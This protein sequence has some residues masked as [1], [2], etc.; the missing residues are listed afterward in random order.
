[1]FVSKA[2]FCSCTGVI[3]AFL[4]DTH[5]R[6]LVEIVNFKEELGV[7]GY[8]LGRFSGGAIPLV[9]APQALG[10]RAAE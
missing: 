7:K 4:V 1:M 6:N 10:H 2:D 8:R 5:E 3:A 9:A